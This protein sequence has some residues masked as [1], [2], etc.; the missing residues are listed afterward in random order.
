MPHLISKRSKLMIMSC[1]TLLLSAVLV[2][3]AFAEDDYDAEGERRAKRAGSE[4]IGTPAPQRELTTLDGK[5]LKLSELY[6]N[7]PVYIKFWATWCVPCRQQMPGFEKIYQ[8]YGDK[9][10]VIAVNTGIGDDK[11]SVS[12][13]VKKEGLTMPVTIDDGALVRA[14][15]LRVTPQ[16]FLIDKSGRVAYVGHKDDEALHQ[17]LETVTSGGL[18]NAAQRNGVVAKKIK[19]TESAEKL[20]TLTLKSNDMATSGTI[21][22]ENAGFKPGDKLPSL[23]LKSIDNI[24]YK[25]PSVNYQSKAT[26]IVFFVPWC[27]GYLAETAPDTAKSCKLV[28]ET[29]EQFAPEAKA[30]WLY[31]SNN[32]WTTQADLVSYQ[33]NYNTSL[34]LFF[35]EESSLF[36]QFGVS[37]LP[38]VVYIDDA[39]QVVEKLTAKTPDFADRLKALLSNQ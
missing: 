20:P 28:R 25:L 26:G 27:E 15:N 38:T 10:Q 8:E 21:I 34:P 24:E 22:D 33:T 7:K 11:N 16:H 19:G 30:Q 5:T 18:P 29:V 17:A 31:V 13:F 1:S 14:F 32:I 12:A 23:T 37:E 39:G 35:D 3:Q 36:G 9:L 6:G 4:L 2:G